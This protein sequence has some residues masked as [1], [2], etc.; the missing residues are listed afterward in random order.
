MTSMTKRRPLIGI[1]CGSI[2]EGGRVKYGQ[3]RSYVK[4]IEDAW[5]GKG[6]GPS[7]HEH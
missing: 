1:T 4:A 6:L 3:N 5:Q 2:G 7:M